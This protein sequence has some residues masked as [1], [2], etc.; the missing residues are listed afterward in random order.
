MIAI[1]NSIILFADLFVDFG[2]LSGLIQKKHTAKS[3]Y[4]SVFFYNLF[5][6]CLIGLIIII[7]SPIVSTFYESDELSFLLKIGALNLVLMSLSK[8]PMT[9]LQKKIRTKNILKINLIAN[10]VSASCIIPLAVYGYNAQA[11]ILKT[12]ISQTIIVIFSWYSVKWLPNIFLSV[13]AL[14]SL[15]GFSFYTFLGTLLETTTKIGDNLIIGKVNPSK[16]LLGFYNRG[17]SLNKLI[18]SF[19]SPGISQVTYPIFSSLQNDNS[20]LKPI[21]LKLY[22]SLLIII[23]LIILILYSNAEE[24]ITLLLGTK[25]ISSATYFKIFLLGNS[26]IIGAILMKVISAKG[27]SKFLLKL[28]ILKK[29]MFYL[30]FTNLF[31]GNIMNY[32]YGYVIARNIAFFINIYVIAKELRI[33]IKKFILPFLINA[34]IVITILNLTFIIDQNVNNPLL[35]M[36]LKSVFIVILFSLLSFGLNI[37]FR[38]EVLSRL[39]K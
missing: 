38:K 33:K 14:K 20:K 4:S 24:L 16:T 3:H 19:I 25:W 2:F 15:I 5:S 34:L 32:I 21:V 28:E 26:S 6:A 9:I 11:I 8:V 30:N 39:K 23:S 35:L 31:Y 29:S 27:K 10:V 22:E 12:T 13:K 1:I 36:I 17:V 7:L 18:I 37:F